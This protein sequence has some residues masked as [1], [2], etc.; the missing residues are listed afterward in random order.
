MMRYIIRT[1][2]YP[3]VYHLSYL[4]F[5]ILPKDHQLN[6]WIY[7]RDLAPLYNDRYLKT[8]KNVLFA[9]AS[10]GEYE[11]V[12]MITQAISSDVN[13]HLMFFSP[14]GYNAMLSNHSDW[15]ILSYSPL[16]DS[17]SLD[18]FFS[19]N[20]FNLAIFSGNYFWPNFL[21]GLA[22]R[23]IPY[24]FLGTTI[25]PYGWIKSQ[26]YAL[27]NPY[28]KGASHIYTHSEKTFIYLK[29]QNIDSVIKTNYLRLATILQNKEFELSLKDHEKFQQFC[30]G[31]K[32]LIL[33]SAH[34]N[35]IKLL[36]EL[37][38]YLHSRYR[39]IIVPHDIADSQISSIQKYFPKSILWSELGHYDNHN[40]LIVNTIGL[41]KELYAYADIC[42]IGGGF[43]RGIHNVL[44]AAVYQKP[45]IIGPKYHK[46]PEV[47]DL[48]NQ[49][50]IQVV[51]NGVELKNAI[52][53]VYN[54]DT[55][56]PE[57]SSMYTQ[58]NLTN[59]IETIKE[60][61]MKLLSID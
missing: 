51:H 3:I 17:S 45:L 58:K 44:E 24:M 13:I 54:L 46:F 4:I 15:Q 38:D 60:E 25:M 22:Y 10:L 29:E 7:R 52:E 49:Q 18:H 48:V 35:D 55:T 36:T 43:D 33:G 47:E 1:I 50:L 32:V 26:F 9:C 57:P 2:F 19:T 37:K 27:F 14:S 5:R 16:E 8:Q 39:V 56:R 11:Y 42:Y 21:E 31:H 6:R 59:D 23:K 40:I 53:Q 30:Q 41:L 28:L 12:K 34:R 61:I 20:H